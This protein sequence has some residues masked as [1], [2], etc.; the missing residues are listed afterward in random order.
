MNFFEKKINNKIL[1]NFN[2]LAIINSENKIYICIKYSK[3]RSR[4]FEKFEL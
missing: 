1:Y 3:F 4:Q 2:F